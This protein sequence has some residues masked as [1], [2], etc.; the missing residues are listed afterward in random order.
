MGSLGQDLRINCIR[1]PLRHCSLMLKSDCS[2]KSYNHNGALLEQH[3]CLFHG[4][5]N[6]N[7]QHAKKYITETNYFLQSY[8]VWKIVFGDD[9]GAGPVGMNSLDCDI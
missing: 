7:M 3:S 6:L 8:S 5:N 1:F 4:E 2:L 9:T